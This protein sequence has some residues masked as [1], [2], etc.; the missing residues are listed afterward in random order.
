MAD[1]KDLEKLIKKRSA[2]KSK[3]TIFNNYV[4]LLKSSPKLSPEQLLDLE[5]RFD[6]FE[7]IYPIFDDLQSD[8]ELLSD[9]PAD[10]CQD[11]EQFEDQYHKLA[12]SAR[13]LLGARLQRDLRDGSVSCYEDVQFTTPSHVLLST[14]LVKVLDG[15]GGAHSARL[16]LDN[17]STA[18]IVTQSLCGK[19]GLSRRDAYSTV[20]GINQHTS[21]CTQSCSLT[22]MSIHDDFKFTVDC[23]I[24]PEIT[25]CLPS[26]FINIESIPLPKGIQ[27]ADPTFNIPSVIDILVGAEVFW[28]VL[29]NN[30]INLG[31]NQP[32]LY[33]TKLGW[34]V[35]GH[36]AR[37]QHSFQNPVCNFLN[38]E[39]NPDLT[40][41]W[42]LDTV[43]AKHS[44][45]PEE[46]ACEQSFLLNTTRKEDGRFVVTMP[47]KEDPSV[48]GDSFQQAKCRFL[49]LERRFN[50]D[51][52]FKEM[53]FTFLLEYEHLGHMT[54][55]KE[56]SANCLPQSP[57]YFMPHHG[58]IRESMLGWLKTPP[59]ELKSFV[60]N[61]V[62]EIQE[63]TEGHTWSYVPSADNPADLVSRGLK[64]DLISSSSLWW[65]G[66]TFLLRDQTHWPK[67]PNEKHDLPELI[68]SSAQQ[69]P[70]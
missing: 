7:A 28:S 8:I 17:G 50:R 55:N 39:S 61:R 56:P 24:L 6:K 41:F 65:S 10:E 44:L 30:Q 27:L 67:K 14:A 54:E 69:F 42:E 9:D 20:T 35:S 70:I 63:S 34:L 46:R 26:S 40:R 33:E 48:L 66:P 37:L 47:L 36:V 68:S 4:T 11:R 64:A 19:L 52:D 53:Y 21:Q 5:G 23:L 59:S 58:V 57:N 15:R 1:S 16:L 2:L 12:A 43:A 38:E 60:R 62:H 25:K 45:S 32:K 13:S 51:P 3:L 22:I 49:S 29:G 31:K 18:N